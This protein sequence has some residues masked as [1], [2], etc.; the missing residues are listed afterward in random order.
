MP[1][2]RNS[3]KRPAARSKGKPRGGPGAASPIRFTAALLSPR[4]MEAAGHSGPKPASWSFLR[5]P[6]DASA[7]LPSRGMVSVT[8]TFNGAPFR[9]TLQPDGQGGHWLKVERKLRE[10]AGAAVGHAVTLEITPAAEEPEPVVPPD[11]K[12]ALAAAPK[13]AREAWS[14]I[15]PAARRD[16]IHWM[17][18]GMKAETRVLRVEKACDMLARGKRRPCCFD[19]SGMYSKSLGC[20]DADTTPAEGA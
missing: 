20:P 4:A 1:M 3:A 7:V 2:N 12:K 5:L 17:T 13:A 8:G 11:L 14:D 9:A 6:R 18:S 15:T 16:W 19:R 10:A